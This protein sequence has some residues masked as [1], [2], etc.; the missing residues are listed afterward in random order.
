MMTFKTKIGTMTFSAM[1]RTVKT[2]KR[3]SY[4]RGKIVDLSTLEVSSPPTQKEI[5]AKY[6][7]GR[8][9][10]MYDIHAGV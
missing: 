9:A 7:A 1:R 6:K 10:E 4:S 3:T 2:F 5:A 8:V